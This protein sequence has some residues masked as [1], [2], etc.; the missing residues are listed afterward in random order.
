MRLLLCLCLGAAI[1]AAQDPKNP[2]RIPPAGIPD[3]PVL[4]P[5]DPPR[6]DPKSVPTVSKS[7]A[8]APTTQIL[9]EVPTATTIDLYA[10]D[11]SIWHVPLHNPGLLAAVRA[12]ILSG[13]PVS[14]GGCANGQCR[15]AQPLYR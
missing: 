1:A 10:A 5:K 3:G 7:A 6:I 2:P 8:A 15:P 11:G 4:A 12:R 14:T 13:I 9:K